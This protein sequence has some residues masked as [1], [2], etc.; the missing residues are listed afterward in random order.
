MDGEWNLPPAASCLT[1]IPIRNLQR[2]KMVN[3]GFVLLPLYIYPSPGLWDPLFT[4]AKAN[5]NVTFQAVINPDNGPGG[6]TCPGADYQNATAYL[7]SIPNIKTLAYVHTANQYNCGT[8][9]KDICPCTV[10]MAQLQANITKYQ[11]W[12]TA[13]CSKNN[14]QDIH[15]DGIFFDESPSDGSCYQYMKNATA[16]AKKTLTRG[17]TVLFNAGTA[18]N[19]T[20]WSI[21]DYINVFE[22]SETVY[23][24]ADIGA[25]DGNGAYSQ[26][27]TLIIYGHSTSTST[28][29]R[30]VQTILS[31]KQDN[32]AGVYITDSNVY[33]QFGSDWQTFA[34]DVAA[35][36]KTNMA[37]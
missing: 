9:G 24:S 8:S 36:V 30:D 25:L 10:P 35:V 22:N 13:G 31:R 4:A 7:N 26:Q 12:P 29:Q 23:D 16:F 34:S 21:A 33:S 37:A 19:S 17:N 27:T 32:I 2:P 15:I 3:Y 5:P 6:S 14:V 1:P 11:N 18:V 20:Y 28:L